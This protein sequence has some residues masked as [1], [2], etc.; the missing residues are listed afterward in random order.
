MDLA[1]RDI[2]KEID[3]IDLYMNANN[4]KS[5][6]YALNNGS[7]QTVTMNEDTI[8]VLETAADVKEKSDGAFNVA[9]KPII[10]L[11]GFGGNYRKVP[12]DSEISAMLETVNNTEIT[13]NGTDVSL[14]GGKIDLGGIGKGFASDKARECLERYQVNY[15][16]V[17]FGG[18][19]LTYGTKPDGSSFKVA[20][21]DGNDSSFAVLEV[22]NTCVITSGG[23]ERYFEENG[24]RYHH[25]LDPST[26]KPA[27]NGLVSVTIISENG[28]LADALS[29]ACFV[30]GKEE[31]MKLAESYGVS[32]VFLDE[33]KNVYTVGN[34]KITI[35]E[36]GYTLK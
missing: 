17:D 29:T 27:E 32:A 2:L 11:W 7:P 6:M 24:K 23:Y 36:D 12:S 28:T 15:A 13:V 21:A 34:V 18:N 30:M 35:T 4:V 10:D 8:K 20:I 1:T 5:K 19:I 14:N 26:G 25:L 9:I 31:G 22:G 16:V 3:N 33:D